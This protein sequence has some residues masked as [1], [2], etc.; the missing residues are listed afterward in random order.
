MERSGAPESAPMGRKMRSN[1][2]AS[3]NLDRL[4]AAGAG[5]LKFARKSA[6]EADVG[7]D[8]FGAAVLVNH[9]GAA[10]CG[11]IAHLLGLAAEIDRA[12]SQFQVE[13]DRL[14]L[15]LA[16]FEF[17]GL[18]LRRARRAVNARL[19]PVIPSFPASRQLANLPSPC[20]Q[21]APSVIWVVKRKGLIVRTLILQAFCLA[22][23]LAI[24]ANSLINRRARLLLS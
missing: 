11:K 1:S 19:D 21:P 14:A 13:F 18:R 7:D 15:Q 8:V 23:F 24:S 6:L 3:G 12:R 16:Y 17:H 9:F 5:N 20:P 22:A 4:D 2:A 10:G